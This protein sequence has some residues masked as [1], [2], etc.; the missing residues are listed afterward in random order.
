MQRWSADSDTQQRS[1]FDNDA[2]QVEALAAKIGNGT[3]TDRPAASAAWANGFWAITD[4]TGGGVVG[5]IYY[6]DGTTWTTVVP[7]TF[8]TDVELADG[9]ATKLGLT[10]KAADSELLDGLDSTAFVAASLLTTKGDLLVRTATGLARK[11]AGANGTVLS[12]DSASADGFSYI[13]P[14]ADCVKIAETVLAAAAASVSFASIPATYRHLRLVASL[15][16]DAAVATQALHLRF[17][18]DATAVYDIEGLSVNLTSVNGRNETAVTSIYDYMD[19]ANSVAGYSS[20]HVIDLPNYAGTTFYKSALLAGASM[21]SA[22][23]DKL[24][25]FTTG[26]WR[27]TAAI[28]AVSLTPNAGNFVTGSVFT[29]Y[30]MK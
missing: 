6:C 18:G 19:G 29:L 11:A 4:A 2:A 23:T 16:G 3:I 24:A 9:L 8:A 5:T 28:N 10:A 26:W 7:D 12:P 1:E 20:P 22:A 17:N 30:G 13:S 15:R 14:P 21:G 25:L 27:S